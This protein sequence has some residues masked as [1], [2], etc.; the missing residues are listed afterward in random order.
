MFSSYDGPEQAVVQFTCSKIRNE[1]KYL[2]VV[3]VVN[4]FDRLSSTTETGYHPLY[5]SGE[6]VSA[7]G[8][9][10]VRRCPTSPLQYSFATT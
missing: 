9:N 10:P 5:L 2:I 3:V 4:R 8:Y 6:A 1:G 7:D